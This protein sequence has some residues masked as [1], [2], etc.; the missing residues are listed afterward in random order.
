[1]LGKLLE[2][3]SYDFALAKWLVGEIPGVVISDL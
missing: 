3:N 1:M 2:T